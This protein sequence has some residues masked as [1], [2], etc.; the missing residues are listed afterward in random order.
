MSCVGSSGML[1]LMLL[2]LP[3]LVAMACGDEDN[4][5]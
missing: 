5:F 4:V 1:P 2:L 3:L